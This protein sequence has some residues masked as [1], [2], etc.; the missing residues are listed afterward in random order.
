MVYHEFSDEHDVWILVG[1]FSDISATT[2]GEREFLE[3][4]HEFRIDQMEGKIPEEGCKMPRLKGGLMRPIIDIDFIPT[5]N[6]DGYIVVR[7]A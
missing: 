4:I 2:D 5:N 3:K 6:I 1:K 7:L